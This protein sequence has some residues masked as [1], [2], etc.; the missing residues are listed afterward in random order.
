MNPLSVCL[1]DIN[2]SRAVANHFFD[3]CC[4]EGKNGAKAKA[5]FER[6]DEKCSAYAMR[7]KN[8]IAVSVDNANIMIEVKNTVAS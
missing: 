7:Y 3:M 1:F 5:I 4:T 6:T 2:R 8:F